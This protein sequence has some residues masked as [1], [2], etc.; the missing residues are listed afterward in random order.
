MSGQETGTDKEI[1]RQTVDRAEG[2]FCRNS[3]VL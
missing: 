2:G 1:G 3:E